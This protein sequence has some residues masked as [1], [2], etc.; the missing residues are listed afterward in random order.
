MNFATSGTSE[1]YLLLPSGIQR[2]IQC[3]SE[4]RGE[5]TECRSL[6]GSGSIYEKTGHKNRVYF[7]V[8]LSS[9]FRVILAAFLPVSNKK[10]K[11][12]KRFSNKIF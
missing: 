12:F 1:S 9:V 2:R 6:R 11:K 8:H 3:V 7:K 5:M 4:C 10:I